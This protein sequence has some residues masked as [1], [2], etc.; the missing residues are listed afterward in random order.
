MT[1]MTPTWQFKHWFCHSLCGIAD[2]LRGVSSNSAVTDV[3]LCCSRRCWVL[4]SCRWSV[5]WWC[6]KDSHS[7]MLYC[8]LV[9]YAKIATSMENPEMSGSLTGFGKCQRKSLVSEIVHCQFMFGVML[10]FS[11]IMQVDLSVR[12]LYHE[13]IGGIFHLKHVLLDCWMR[14]VRTE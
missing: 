1:S 10:V 3:C 14:W 8:G 11:S 4:E 9:P 13:K 12:L 7:S 5:R 6:S 2:A